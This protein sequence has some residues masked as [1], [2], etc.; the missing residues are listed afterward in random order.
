MPA[1]EAKPLPETP[2]GHDDVIKWKHFPHY[3]PFARGIHR[4][5]V[6]S[7][8][9]GQWRGALMF[10]L[11]CVWINGWVNNHETLSRPLWRHRNETLK[12]SFRLQTT[13][14]WRQW[15]PSLITRIEVPGC[16][17]LATI[18]FWIFNYD[19]LRCLFIIWTVTAMLKNLR[20]QL[21]VG[22][23]K[24]SATCF[25]LCRMIDPQIGG[26]V[27]FVNISENFDGQAMLKLLLKCCPK[28]VL[29]K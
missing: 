18:D 3:W 24:K 10:S 2:T 14:R 13:I 27:K 12:A 22:M 23:Y 17:W 21:P 9:K 26:G 19:C 4:S 29:Q 20:F 15:L 11:I 5:P 6:N 16:L 1:W 8:Q 7:P 28:M 25:F